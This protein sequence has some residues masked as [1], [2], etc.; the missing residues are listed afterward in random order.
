MEKCTVCNSE[1][2]HDSYKVIAGTKYNIL[3]CKTCRRMVA[4]SEK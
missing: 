1:M 4:K 3:K 2:E